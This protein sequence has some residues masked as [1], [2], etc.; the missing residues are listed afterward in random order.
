MNFK[1]DK[2]A[3]KEAVKNAINWL[4]QNELIKYQV[5]YKR[6]DTESEKE[7]Y[8]GARWKDKVYCVRKYDQNIF[9]SQKIYN[10]IAPLL[11]RGG[12]TRGNGVSLNPTRRKYRYYVFIEDLK[13]K[14]QEIEQITTTQKPHFWRHVHCLS[15]DNLPQDVIDN[16]SKNKTYIRIETDE[17]DNHSHHYSFGRNC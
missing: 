3:K 14:I 12:T 7:F 10:I 8:G 5:E 16:L 6:L 1:R 2:E 4:I 15:K 17:E 13:S 11:V 9:T